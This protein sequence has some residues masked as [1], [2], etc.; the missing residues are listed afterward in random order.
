MEEFATKELAN[1]WISILR[2]K[3]H[4]EHEERAKGIIVPEPSIDNI[5]NEMIAYFSGVN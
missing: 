2:Q 5:C 1:R 3:A 4:Y